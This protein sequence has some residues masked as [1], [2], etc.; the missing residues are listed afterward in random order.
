ML[1]KKLESEFRVLIDTLKEA[2]YAWE[3]LSPERI[4]RLRQE[5]ADL[6]AFAR[7]FGLGLPV[8]K[9]E[10]V[11]EGLSARL[12]ESLSPLRPAVSR[13]GDRFTLHAHWDEPASSG[14]PVYLGPESALLLECIEAC[15][16]R[17]P[18]LLRGR[19]GIDLGSGAGALSIALTD[20]AEGILGI[21]A[22][23]R[24]V[25]WSTASA[26]AQGLDRLRFVH[27]KIGEAQ[28]DFATRSARQIDFAVFNPPMAVPVR[29]QSRIQRDGGELGIELP[30]AFLDHAGRHLPPG[31][32]VFCLA[33]NPIVGGRPV[34]FDRLASRDWIIEER[35]RLNDQFNRSL[36]RKDG[37]AELGIE[38]IE[39]WFLHLR[40]PSR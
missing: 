30:L 9:E 13:R 26:A 31:G 40:R 7:Y 29:G 6:S 4:Q 17:Q 27:A 8:P 12:F 18:D 22:S 23:E 21:E 5:A 14:G 33:T 10:L 38:R 1:G 37:Y 2:H 39:L 19:H 24:A 25:L 16:T 20:V 36:A 34:F 11:E 28:A 32:E 3:I 35:K 15:I